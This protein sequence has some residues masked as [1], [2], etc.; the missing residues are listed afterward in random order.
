MS[1]NR[2][3]VDE[4]GSSASGEDANLLDGHNKHQSAI[5]NSGRHK[6]SRKATGDAIVDAMLEN[7]R[8]FENE[9]GCNHEE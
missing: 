5:P 6:R 9:S 1:G 4:D 7:S 3:F 8:C 2:T